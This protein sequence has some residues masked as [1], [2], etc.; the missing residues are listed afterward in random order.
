MIDE[1]VG[2]AICEKTCCA[3]LHKTKYTHGLKPFLKVHDRRH[4]TSSRNNCRVMQ[5][6]KNCSRHPERFTAGFTPVFVGI[7]AAQHSQGD[8][9]LTKRLSR[10]T[11]VFATVFQ[12]QLPGR[13]N[14][15][16]IIG[17]VHGQFQDNHVRLCNV[18]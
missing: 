12:K 5:V 2:F 7:I 11:V 4:T 9:H 10:F 13:G 17:G 6:L 18:Q 3:A 1:K 16:H 15:F 14:Q 8:K